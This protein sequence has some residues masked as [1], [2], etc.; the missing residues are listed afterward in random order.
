MKWSFQQM[1]TVQLYTVRKRLQII[2]LIYMLFCLR[3]SFSRRFSKIFL[4]FLRSSL[5]PLHWLQQLLIQEQN[6]NNVIRNIVT[7][8]NYYS[9]KNNIKLG[10]Y[11]VFFIDKSLLYAY[12]F[13]HFIKIWILHCTT[14]RHI[15]H[16]G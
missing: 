5:N 14:M 16:V 6:P 9:I 15:L 3:S 10:Y 12:F 2:S 13:S 1:N 7:V 4:I 8:L 11:N